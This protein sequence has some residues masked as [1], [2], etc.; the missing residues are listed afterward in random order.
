[1][2]LK[3]AGVSVFLSIQL[4]TPAPAQAASLP[5]AFLDGGILSELFSLAAP[6]LQGLAT[7]LLD[8]LS[9]GGIDLSNFIMDV[10]FSSDGV[11]SE[12]GLNL[13][14]LLGAAGDALDPVLDD[15]PGGQQI[16]SILS[17]LLNGSIS[18]QSLL[19]GGLLQSIL[20]EILGSLL[21]GE[22]PDG[23][24]G[25][26]PSSGRSGGNSPL[27]D[28]TIGSGG[29]SGTGSVTCLYASTCRPN[30]NPYKTIFSR[31]TGVQG[32]PN[33]NEVRGKIYQAAT[34]GK[35]LS[36]VYAPNSNVGAYY[37]GNQSDRD[38]NRATTEA[39]LSKA[40][41]AQQKQTSNTAKETV[42]AVTDLVKNCAATAKSSQELIRCNLLVDSVGPSFDAAQLSVLMKM[43][44]DGQFQKLQLGNIS[45][46]VD[47]ERRQ[48]DVENAGL[49]I[50][51]M[52]AI[53]TTPTKW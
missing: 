16:Y 2:K 3:Q 27:P 29:V 17:G 23:S 6:F 28:V 14:G 51:S 37:A 24:S 44:Q 39:Y 4:L 43:Q 50:S 53:W 34:S 10:V 8:G 35:I 32:Y 33:P 26:S 21:G 38:I 31:A 47:A 18:L 7:D 40:G 42:R 25:G 13:G 20:S 11:L 46:S 30:S 52:K 48:R 22:Q 1:M 36:D 15:L 45:A 41:Q 5:L 19:K 49:S 9:I 12:G